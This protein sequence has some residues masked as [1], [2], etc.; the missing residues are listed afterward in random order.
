[1]CVPRFVSIIYAAVTFCASSRASTPTCLST[2]T[3]PA[4]THNRRGFRDSHTAVLASEVVLQ[5]P[6]IRLNED[7]PRAC[8][9]LAAAARHGHCAHLGAMGAVELVLIVSQ[10]VQVVFPLEQRRRRRPERAF[11]R[12]VPRQGHAEQ[13]RVS[14]LPGSIFRGAK[15][16]DSRCEP[17]VLSSNTGPGALSASA[18][19]STAIR[20]ARANSIDPESKR[21]RHAPVV[22]RRRAAPAVL[23]LDRHHKR[24]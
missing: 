1:M 13:A 22:A 2:A 3:V 7:S 10:R 8:L 5:V 12:P 20:G 18:L 14:G 16:I 24:A 4:P 17:I 15:H 9:L 11:F 19:A 21:S 23:R 6:P